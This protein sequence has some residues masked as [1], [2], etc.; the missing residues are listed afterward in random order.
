MKCYNHS[1]REAVVICRACGKAVCQE[2]GL[3][4]ENGFACQ[5]NCAKTLAGINEHYAGQAAHL[6]NIKRMNFLGSLFSIGMGLLFI[7]FSFMGYGVVYDL[8]LLLGAGFTF[9]GVMAQLVNM[10]IFFKI[11]K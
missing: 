8:L 6:R 5:R 11:K 7:Y 4:T 9:Y 1:E 10:I 2:C 3:E